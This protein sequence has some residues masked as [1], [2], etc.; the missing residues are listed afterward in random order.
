MEFKGTKEDALR[1]LDVFHAL[2]PKY[3]TVEITCE[4]LADHMIMFHQHCKT[5]VEKAAPELLEFAMEMVKRYPNSPWIYEQGQ[6]A[7]NKA[8]NK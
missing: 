7:I 8:L 1:Y 5:D 3:G 6:K 2:E 4:G